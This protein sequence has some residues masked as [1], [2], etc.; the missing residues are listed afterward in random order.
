MANLHSTNIVFLIGL[1]IYVA[2]RKHYMTRLQYAETEVNAIDQ[3]D[4]I[5][6]AAVALTVIVLP[7]LYLLTPLFSFADYALSWKL[8]ILGSGVI[9]FSLLL[10][11]RSHADLGTNWSPSLEIRRDH[12]L[13]TRGVYSRVRHPMYTSIWLWCLG[14]GLMLPNWFIAWAPLVCFSLMYF[15]R[16]RREEQIMRDRFGAEYDAYVRVTGRLFPKGKG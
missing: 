1:V 16:I 5:L 15:R 3:K 11:W 7:V 8:R 9:A 10:F 14:Q 13:I 4:R 2:I 12:R 6:M